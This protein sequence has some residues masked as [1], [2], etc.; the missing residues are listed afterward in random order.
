[1]EG[2]PFQTVVIPFIAALVL[3]ARKGGNKGE[4][5]ER[6]LDDIHENLIRFEG[7]VRRMK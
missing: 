6:K 1:M 3:L 4:R 5:A 7:I 2:F